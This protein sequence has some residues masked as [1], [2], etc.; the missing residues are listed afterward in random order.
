LV[1]VDAC[2]AADAAIAACFKCELNEADSDEV[3]FHKKN[4]ELFGDVFAALA[5]KLFQLTVA[6]HELEAARK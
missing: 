5:E 6:K 4:D 2:L 1:A 3:E